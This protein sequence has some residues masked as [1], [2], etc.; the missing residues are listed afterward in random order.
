MI[1]AK[2]A[3]LTRVVAS[4][5]AAPT[6]AP[7]TLAKVSATIAA[8]PIAWTVN[9][10]VGTRSRL[11]R[12][13][14]NT[15][16]R[17]AMVAGVVTSTAIQP[18]T[19]AAASPYA[20][21]RKTYTPPVRGSIELSSATVRAPQMQMRPNATHNAMMRR[22]FGTSAAIVGGVR[23]MPLPMVMP[24]MSAVPLEKP[25]TLRRSCVTER[26]WGSPQR[27]NGAMLNSGPYQR[28]THGDRASHTTTYSL[29]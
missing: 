26:D 28:G 27:R 17:A 4:L 29:S 7:S 13:S 16:A 22:G 24:T 1:A 3:T 14:P 2:A 18:N 10:P 15:V 25:M 5:T 9:A 12:N 21:R 11:S 20:S 19:K 8:M 6:R 23:K